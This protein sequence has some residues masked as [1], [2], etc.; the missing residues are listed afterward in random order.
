M[1]DYAKHDPAPELPHNLIAERAVLGGILVRNE[2][3][4]KVSDIVGEQHFYNT[5]HAE[6]F[7]VIAGL[8]QEGTKANAITLAAHFAGHKPTLDGQSM[9]DYIRGLMTAD[10]FTGGI[11]D[12]ARQI[13][14]LAC[15]RELV[16]IAQQMSEAAATSNIE[17]KSKAI[18]EEAEK[19]LYEVAETGPAM[20]A[21]SLGDAIAA[22]M[23]RATEAKAAGGREKGIRTGLI[24]L[25]RKLGGL[26]P[27]NLIIIAGRP[28]MGKTAL[29]TGIGFHAAKSDIPVQMYSM[30]MTN[31]E[32]GL[33][34]LAEHSG[35]D[36]NDILSGRLDDEKFAR[37]KAASKEISGK[38]FWIDQTGGL[39]V[40]KLATRARR[41]KRQQKIG[42]IVIDYLQLMSGGSGNRVQD[43]TEITVGLKALAKELNVPIVALSQLSRKVEERP[44]KRPQLADLRE[45]GSIEQDADV[46]MFV[47]REEYYLEREKPPL[48]EAAK[49]ADWQAKMSACQGKA[50]VIIGKQRHGS[51]GIVPVHFNAELTQFCSL[52]SDHGGTHAS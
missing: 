5:I 13:Y 45:S 18:I 40:A 1:Q 26:V 32:L 25:D 50:E 20:V 2:A 16:G 49:Y 12:Y 6:I 4:D 34:L 11:P 7:S 24:D 29:A 21:V 42:L 19:A 37:I 51:V 35:I 9:P 3:F 15:R 44:D 22:V 47:F 41:V 39:S 52:A 27:G 23:Q 38:P 14:E 36:G 17:V 31:D 43:V 33:R 46:V 30:E 48:K 8:I 10:A 28:S